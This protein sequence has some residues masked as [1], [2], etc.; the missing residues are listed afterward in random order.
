MADTDQR[1]PLSTNIG[2]AGSLEKRTLTLNAKSVK[3]P[4]CHSEKQ[5]QT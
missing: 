3:L 1:L 2:F 5:K 4:I